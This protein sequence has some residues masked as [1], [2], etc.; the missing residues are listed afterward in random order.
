MANCFHTAAVDVEE[1]ASFPRRLESA[2]GRSPSRV[3]AGATALQYRALTGK[4]P[5]TTDPYEAGNN[6]PYHDLVRDVF[7][8]A[9]FDGWAYH[10]RETAREL[11]RLTKARAR[12][13]NSMADASPDAALNQPDVLLAKLASTVNGRIAMVLD[14]TGTLA[15]HAEAT[16][17]SRRVER[18]R[19]LP[20]AP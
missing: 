3:V 20:G 10:S 18:C 11:R 17:R 13:R 12:A 4:A 8:L 14:T 15:L 2:L 6:S 19:K 9:G 1:N 7:A 5:A 16:E